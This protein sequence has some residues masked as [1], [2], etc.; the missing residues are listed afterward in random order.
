MDFMT[1]VNTIA[2][3]VA[4]ANLAIALRYLIRYARGHTEVHRVVGTSD[5]YLRLTYK[6]GRLTAVEMWKGLP[7]PF[8]GSMSHYYVWK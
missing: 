7:D 1:V 2:F 4:L 5:T 6:R 3:P 8:T